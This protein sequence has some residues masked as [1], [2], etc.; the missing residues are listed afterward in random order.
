MC[1][2]ISDV[3]LYTKNLTGPQFICLAVLTTEQ[4]KAYSKNYSHLLIYTFVKIYVE[5]Y[6][7]TA[8]LEACH[9]PL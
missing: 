9:V 4:Y 3:T 8:T 1:A 7:A 2:G 5:I 6:L